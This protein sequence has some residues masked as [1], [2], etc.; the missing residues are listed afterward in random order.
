MKQRSVILKEPL[1]G[2]TGGIILIISDSKLAVN[3]LVN[4]WQMTTFTKVE[5]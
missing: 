2:Q 4:T 3:L 5:F 1:S